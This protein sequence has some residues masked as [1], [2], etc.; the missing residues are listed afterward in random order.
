MSIAI[1][2]VSGQARQGARR[3]LIV[4]IVLWSLPGRVESMPPFGADERSVTVSVGIGLHIPGTQHDLTRLLGDA[5]E[6]LYRAKANGRNR[7]EGPQV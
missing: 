3:K 4:Q 6:A 1:S 7:V 2:A 5:D